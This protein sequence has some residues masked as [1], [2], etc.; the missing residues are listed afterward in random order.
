MTLKTWIISSTPNKFLGEKYILHPGSKYIWKTKQQRAMMNSKEL[1][2]GHKSIRGT[3][4]KPFPSS[5]HCQVHPASHPYSSQIQI[6]NTFRKNTNTNTLP[7]A[8]SQP[9]VL[10]T[11]TSCNTFTKKIFQT[12]VQDIKSA[13]KQ[14]FP[15][16]AMGIS[17]AFAPQIWCIFKIHLLIKDFKCINSCTLCIPPLAYC[18][19]HKKCKRRY[20][21]LVN[22]RT[23]WR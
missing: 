19:R 13:L 18:P 6:T 22:P 9:A 17:H 1:E 23:L 20:L 21:E 8:P 3:L 12:W 11:K 7:S 2:S 14:I 4:R 16:S 15:L 5:R 10:N